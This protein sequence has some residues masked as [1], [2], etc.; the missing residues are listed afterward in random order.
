MAEI[1]SKYIYC[2]V[3][4]GLSYLRAKGEEVAQIPLTWGRSLDGFGTW[5]GHCRLTAPQEEPSQMEPAKATGKWDK[6]LARTQKTH[7]HGAGLL[8]HLLM[9]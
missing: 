4:K 2:C 6:P 3:F 1:K 7:C 9:E 5:E 8:E